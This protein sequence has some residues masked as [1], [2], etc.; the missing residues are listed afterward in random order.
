M[1]LPV[2]HLVARRPKWMKGVH[3]H[4][5]TCRE[6]GSCLIPHGEQPG[7]PR[8]LDRWLG[9]APRRSQRGGMPNPPETWRDQCPLRPRARQEAL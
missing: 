2:C 6:A 7:H 4:A 1:C 3:T 5:N 8:P 9:R